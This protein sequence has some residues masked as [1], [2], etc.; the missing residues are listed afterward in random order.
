VEHVAF[1]ELVARVEQDLLA[2]ECRLE[3][4]EREGVLELVAEAERAAR[5]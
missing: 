1:H 5:L 2:R 3:R 4:R